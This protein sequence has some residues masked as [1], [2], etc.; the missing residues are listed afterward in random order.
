MLEPG[1][2][3]TAQRA[4][5]DYVVTEFGIAELRGKSLKQRAATLLEVA[6]PDFQPD[7]RRE[8]ERIYHI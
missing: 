6:H 1:S 3:V 2:V 7:L 8:A 4:F 5:V